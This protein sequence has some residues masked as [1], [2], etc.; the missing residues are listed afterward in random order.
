MRTI[1]ELEA[2]WEAAMPPPRDAG[3]LRLIC[4]RK[5]AGLHETPESAEV[6]ARD[7]L[8]GDR[9]ANR[10]RG[11]DPDGAAAVTLKNATVADLVTAGRLPLDAPGDNLLVDLDLSIDALPPGTEIGIGSDVV[12]RV[13]EEPHTGCSKYRDRFGLD[14]LKWVS[15][16]DGKRRRLRGMNCSVLS[17]GMVRVGDAIRVL[18]R[19]TFPPQP[20]EAAA[21]V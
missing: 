20:E 11:K 4:L 10:G 17:P 21:A 12:L 9:W 1:E 19:P 18:R 3:T 8:R 2:G 6:T 7:G 15:T 13:S 14:A 16:P 5:D